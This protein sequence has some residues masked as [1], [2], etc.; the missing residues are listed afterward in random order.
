MKNS[1]ESFTYWRSRLYQYHLPDVQK[2]KTD[3]FLINQ[4]GDTIDF[5]LEDDFGTIRS[6]KKSVLRKFNTPH[7]DD[8]FNQTEPNNVRGHHMLYVDDREK[9]EILARN[10]YRFY[11]RRSVWAFQ[12]DDRLALLKDIR[13]R[14]VS[15][16]DHGLVNRIDEVIGLLKE[17]YA[18][19]VS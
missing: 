18:K 3:I 2:S 12:S 9:V 1:T 17:K 16:D 6:V 4:E 5:V 19:K 15:L 14:A 11:F 8:Y 13:D 10:P 7:I